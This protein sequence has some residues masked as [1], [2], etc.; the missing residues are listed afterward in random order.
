MTNIQY[1]YTVVGRIPVLTCAQC[2]LVSSGH[3]SLASPPG[4]AAEQVD[5][6]HY[7]P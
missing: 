3:I 4:T 6:K 2:C 5:G 7:I 1:Y